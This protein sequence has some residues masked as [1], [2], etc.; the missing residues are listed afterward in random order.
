MNV[1]QTG[2]I[3]AP[4]VAN[5]FVYNLQTDDTL[6]LLEISGAF[7]INAQLVFEALPKGQANWFPA[8]G[9]EQDTQGVVTGTALAPL[10]IAQAQNL[11]YKFDISG[12]QA[13][14]VWAVAL[15]APMTVG[16][17]TGSFFAN[18]PSGAALSLPIQLAT[19]WQLNHLTFLLGLLDEKLGAQWQPNP[20]LPAYL[21][22]PQWDVQG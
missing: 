9:V 2:S 4:G 18:P 5:A 17:T 8:G 13:F 14:R 19:L 22:P 20:L 15:A 16:V 12:C 10:P 11:A 3:P 7:G 21:Q 1:P 6:L